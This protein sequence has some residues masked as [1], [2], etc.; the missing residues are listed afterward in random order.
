M[1]SLAFFSYIALCTGQY[2]NRSSV[3]PQKMKVVLGFKHDVTL[4]CS[5]FQEKH[6]NR[7]MAVLELIVNGECKFVV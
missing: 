4:K 6:E 2:I 5:I 7:V 1:A 3:R